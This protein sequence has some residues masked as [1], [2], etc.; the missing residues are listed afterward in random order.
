MKTPVIPKIPVIQLEM[1]FPKSKR[2]RFALTDKSGARGCKN[3]TVQNP[4]NNQRFLAGDEKPLPPSWGNLISKT[5][6]KTASWEL[7]LVWISERSYR[8]VRF[9]LEPKSNKK[10]D[11]SR[12]IF[13][14]MPVKFR[15]LQK[16]VV[17]R[18]KWAAHEEW[19]ANLTCI[20][21]IQ[22]APEL[23]LLSSWA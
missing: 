10:L 12:Q 17:K 23:Q 15:P 5:L 3:S 14:S 21:G 9:D 8:A 7:C 18:Y 11:K 13:I 2:W 22:T 19:A 1:G 4:H 20:N 6:P 16:S